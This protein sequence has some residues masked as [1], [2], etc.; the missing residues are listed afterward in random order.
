MESHSDFKIG[1]RRGK[2]PFAAGAPTNAKPELFSR[3]FVECDHVVAHSI[4]A[5][6][7]RR[8]VLECIPLHDSFDSD[9][10]A[11]DGSTE[12]KLRVVVDAV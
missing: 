3:A 7:K 2:E 4:P 5:I 1:C 12:V 9:R 8:V 10:P 11:K 6:K